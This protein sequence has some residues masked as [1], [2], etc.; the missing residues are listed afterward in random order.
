MRSLCDALW[1]RRQVLER[2]GLL[3]REEPLGSGLDSGLVRAELL[4]EVSGLELMGAADAES[5]EVKAESR[6]VD[7]P[8]EDS[9]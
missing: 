9:A 4:A 7:D 1:I 2:L 3:D 5:K 8:R 6:D